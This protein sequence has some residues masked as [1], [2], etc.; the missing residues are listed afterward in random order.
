MMGCE[1]IITK[2]IDIENNY[3]L[4]APNAISLSNPS[5]QG[6]MPFALQISNVEFTLTIFDKNGLLLFQTNDPNDPWR[7]INM[8]D[9]SIVPT[10]AA[11]VWV[12]KLKNGNGVYEEYTENFNCPSL[13][14]PSWKNIRRVDSEMV[15]SFF[16]VETRKY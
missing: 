16:M 7:G 11:Y 4:L 15:N 3:N 5:D 9:N 1:Q 8:S 13:K 2:V 12:V 14:R 6:F 10:E